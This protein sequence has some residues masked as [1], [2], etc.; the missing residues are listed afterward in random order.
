MQEQ[1]DQAVAEALSAEVGRRRPLKGAAGKQL[2]EAITAGMYSNPLMAIREYV[3]NA[4]DAVDTAIERGVLAAG[5]ERIDIAVSGRDRSIVIED[6]GCGVSRSKVERVLGGVGRSEKA[7]D[8]H[9]GFR[10][11]GRLAGLAYCERLRF[12]TR[13]SGREAVSVVQW[14]GARLR[15]LVGEA[16][17]SDGMASVVSRLAELGWRKARPDEPGR[18]FRVTMG[19]VNRFHGDLLLNVTELGRYLSQVAPVPY[20][21]SRFS[22]WR[23]IEKHMKGIPGWRSYRIGLN[24]RR[25]LRPYSDDIRFGEAKTDRIREIELLEF[26]G[27]DGSVI[28]RGWYAVSRFLGAMPCSETMRGIR[29]RHGNIEVGNDRFLEPMYAEPRFAVWHIGEV[30]LVRSV[31]PNARRDGFEQLPEYERFLAHTALLGRKLTAMCRAASRQRSRTESMGAKLNRAQQLLSDSSLF[32]DSAHA[33]SVLGKVAALMDKVRPAAVDGHR[34]TK[35]GKRFNELSRRLRA[36]EKEPPLLSDH[37][38]GRK[39]AG[40]CTKDFLVALGRR[41]LEHHTDMMER[42]GA[43]RHILAPYL[44]AGACSLP[45]HNRHRH[46]LGAGAGRKKT[47]QR[48]P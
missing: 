42:D 47:R 35:L 44:K 34:N 37:I 26:T 20:D 17:P 13:S 45:A 27:V 38:D 18:F 7:G 33:A 22:F 15:E 31:R 1:G 16:D 5:K 23:R 4:A 9:R 39:L 36:L 25:I 3:Q 30:E 29:V 14:D 19:G 12:E 28:G 10:G 8:E 11:I 41:I 6:N 48:K 2:L 21:T 24:G 43:L 40:E 32:I 46:G